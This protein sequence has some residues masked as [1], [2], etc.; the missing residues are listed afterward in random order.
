MSDSEEGETCDKCGE[1]VGWGCECDDGE[2]SGGDD[3]AVEIENGY[4]EADGCKKEN[5]DHALE[6]FK[7]VV[8]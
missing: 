3:V 4:H 2:G 7:K 6:L 1:V 5:P 8:E